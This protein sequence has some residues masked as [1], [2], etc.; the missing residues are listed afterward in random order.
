M[1]Q[2][3]SLRRVSLDSA[4]LTLACLGSLLAD[5]PKPS[6]VDAAKAAAQKAVAERDAAVKLRDAKA[7]AAKVEADKA[8]GAKANADKLAAE[9]TSME[10]A[11]AAKAAAV[12]TASDAA[13]A[14]KAV[15]DK[16]V[17]DQA[18]AEKAVAE[19]EAAVRAA[20]ETILAE[21]AFAAR[22]NLTAARA[23]KDKALKILAEKSAAVDSKTQE[24][25][26][27]RAASGKAE[28]EKLAAEK[29]LADKGAAEKIATEKLAALSAG[30]PPAPEQL[31]A[32]KS[33]V[34]KATAE[35]AEAAK[36]AADKAA[37]AKAAAD[38]ASAAANAEAGATK[39][40][41][42]ADKAVAERR[43]AEAGA[44]DQSA[45]AEAELIGGLKPLAG[46]AWDYNKARHLLWRAGFGGTAEEVAKLHSMG[47]HAAVDHLVEYQRQPAPATYVD[48]RQPERETTY[49]NRLT[50]PERSKLGN[51][52]TSR[53]FEQQSNLRQWW[54]RRMVETRRPLEEK[55]ALFWHGHFAVAFTKNENPYAMYR[56]NQLFREYAGVNFAGLLRG[57][58]QDPA[59]ITYLDNQVNFKG[60][61]NE[62]LGRE[63]LELFSMGEGQGYTEQD[64]REAARALTGYNYDYQT[65]QFKFVATRHDETAKTIF[66]RAGIWGGDELV[67]LI[68][69]QPATARFIVSKLF[70]FL[71]HDK[72]APETIER[73]AGVLRLRGYELQ[74]LLRNLF[75]SE[76]FYGDAALA[77]HIKSPV[78]LMVGTLCALG[79]TEANYAAMDAA[80][81]SMGQTLF[82]PPNVKG[83]DGGR[84]WINAGRLMVRY[85]SVVALVDQGAVDLIAV[86]ERHQL[87][88]ADAVVDFLAN[89]FLVTPLGADK[90]AALIQF[91]GELPPP[92][93][94]GKQRDALN[95]KL[96]ALLA[97]LLSGPEYQLSL[98]AAPPG[99]LFAFAS[100]H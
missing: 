60:A 3:A 91:L 69:Q 89:G 95:A 84:D 59:M 49:E 86:L 100:S 10:Q 52:R 26:A 75:L 30:A 33:A 58:A 74:P 80:L 76:E 15:A 92:A 27:A 61:G 39:E 44:L 83:W 31:A 67:D 42:D 62:N 66:G 78:E 22:E 17:A 73:L 7:A 77:S 1:K 54:L 32:G 82:E 9:K 21:A 2:T 36:L 16:A 38:K 43:V 45:L 35:K 51:Q 72:P 50:E 37:A 87:R 12:K 29:A 99:L 71:V 88:K 18:A 97:T 34:A 53:R 41:A 93:D 4:L 8:A 85:N 25:A 81:Q 40:K 46:S 65:G 11:L 23:E 14:A 90:R 47:L 70:R 24:A 68:L 48:V 6:P 98:R 55:L 5:E 13:A 28:A 19:K 20:Q 57:I 79:L 64:L 56:Q 96:R 94:W 63:I